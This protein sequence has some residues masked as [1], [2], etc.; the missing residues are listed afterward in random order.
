[1]TTIRSMTGFGAASREVAGAR[2]GVEIRSVNNKF[3]KTVV[4]LPEELATIETE[5][6]TAVAKKVR[7][8]SVMVTV[9]FVP[10]GDQ[11]AG[12]LNLEVARRMVED[13]HQAMPGELRDRAS[14]D[15]STLLLVPAITESSG[16]DHLV[17]N[18]RPI[19]MELLEEACEHL[20][21]M[22][23]REGEAVRA[24]LSDF[25]DR[26]RALL[27]EI[28]TRAPQV[29]ELY[30]DRLHQRIGSLLAEVG[31]N[32]EESD[33]VR[34]V[35]IFAERSD[36]AEEILRL[37]GHIDQFFDLLA[38]DSGEPVGRTLDFLTQEMLR[39]ANTIASKSSDVTI[40]RAVVEVKGLI[41]RIK[42][43]AANVE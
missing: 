24:E 27:E 7:R 32:L 35:A 19:L 36:I 30:R 13:L 6:E 5:L 18:A 10:G 39:E 16:S 12:S 29:V 34:E 3:L 43:Q 4:R 1:M 11:I 23:T 2:Y 31:T 41:D 25:G 15:L 22:R 21:E 33:L 8:G 42:E 20:V 40:T 26:M 37:G 14:I 9:R 17:E 28:S 38:T